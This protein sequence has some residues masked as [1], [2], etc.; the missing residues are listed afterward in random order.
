VLKRPINLLQ[1]PSGFAAAPKV[2][3]VVFSLNPTDMM[4]Q[5]SGSPRQTTPFNELNFWSPVVVNPSAPRRQAQ[6]AAAQALA[7]EVPLHGTLS[8]GAE[9]EVRLCR[10]GDA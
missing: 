6:L 8:P 10:S 3:I 7:R 1:P 4:S 5:W 9:C 2:F